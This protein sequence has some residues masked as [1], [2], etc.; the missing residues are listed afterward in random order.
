MFPNPLL[1]A[2]GNPKTVDSERNQQQQEPFDPV[3]EQANC[4]TGEDQALAINE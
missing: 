2:R 4:R 1:N 3:S